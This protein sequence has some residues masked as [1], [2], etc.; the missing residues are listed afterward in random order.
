[1]RLRA[2]FLPIIATSM[3]LCASA[4]AQSLSDSN[5]P[6]AVFPVESEGA[7]TLKLYPPLADALA[8]GVVIIPFKT[9]NARILPVFGSAAVNVT[10]RIAHLHIGVDD[11]PGTWTLATPDPIVVNQLRPGVHKITVQLSDPTHNI[12]LTQTATVTVP[13]TK[14]GATH[15]HG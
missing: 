2:E 9:E 14:A 7:P 15:V 11:W 3:L 8:R 13:E 1:M 12:L 5:A 6:P 10:P 4:W